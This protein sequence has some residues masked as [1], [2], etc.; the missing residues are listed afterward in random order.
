MDLLNNIEPDQI[1][2]REYGICERKCTNDRIQRR[3]S[4]SWKPAAPWRYLND[5]PAHESHLVELMLV[6]GLADLL[7]LA[8]RDLVPV[9]HGDRIRYPGGNGVAGLV[10]E[11]IAFLALWL[12]PDS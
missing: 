3:A 11:L 9:I 2:Y 12:R 8:R 7:H 10:A 6:R 4:V 1:Q 5:I